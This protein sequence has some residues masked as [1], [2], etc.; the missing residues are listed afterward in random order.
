[1][2]GKPDTLSVTKEQASKLG[3]DLIDNLIAMHNE[4]EWIS[5]SLNVTAGPKEAPVATMVFM[6][7]TTKEQAKTVQNSLGSLFL[8]L[9]Q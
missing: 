5:L 6:P 9:N 7:G 2:I 4:G 1:M 3:H 8:K